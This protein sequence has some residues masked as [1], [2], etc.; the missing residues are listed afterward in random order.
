MS[1]I[2]R[3]SKQVLH[4]IG[5]RKNSF[6]EK[7]Y[8]KKLFVSGVWLHGIQ[9]RWSHRTF[10]EKKK[11]KFGHPKPKTDDYMYDYNLKTRKFK[12]VNIRIS[13]KR[14][15]SISEGKLK[16][17]LK[18]NERLWNTIQ[19]TIDYIKGIRESLKNQGAKKFKG[20]IKPKVI[21]K[22]IINNFKADFAKEKKKK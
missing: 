4:C 15:R 12:R 9:D 21:Y 20:K 7:E 16:N 6:T 3:E 13:K 22:S 11:Y 5:G 18:K 14:L 10:E 8:Y 19:D 2:G 1:Y 17:L